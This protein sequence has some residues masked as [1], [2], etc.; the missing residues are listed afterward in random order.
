[1][2]RELALKEQQLVALGD[3][4]DK[5]QYVVI[6][7]E[8]EIKILKSDNEKLTKQVQTSQ[9]MILNLEIIEDVIEEKERNVIQKMGSSDVSE[10]HKKLKGDFKCTK[11]VDYV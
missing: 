4:F 10:D 2:S 3:G 5:E 9:E 11:L 8:E 7:L 1:M 6:D